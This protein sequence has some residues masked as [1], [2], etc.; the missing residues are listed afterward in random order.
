MYILTNLCLVN[1][2]NSWKY[3]FI[4]V[5]LQW[6]IYIAKIS[7]VFI[8]PITIRVGID[9][10][11]H[12]CSV[13]FYPD[14]NCRY[15]FARYVIKYVLYFTWTRELI[16]VYWLS[17]F[18]LIS[19]CSF[20]LEFCRLTERLWNPK[21]FISLYTQCYLCCS[22]MTQLLEITT[23]I[24]LLSLLVFGIFTNFGTFK[25]YDYVT[26]ALYLY[27]PFAQIVVFL[28]ARASIPCAIQAFEMTRRMLHWKYLKLRADKSRILILKTKVLRPLSVDVGL[29]DFRFFTLKRSTA[30]T[31]WKVCIDYTIATLLYVHV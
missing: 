18:F 26:P 17:Y 14:T 21:M 9:P 1:P 3:T 11:L 29:F 12:I 16:R 22:R 5:V 15:P 23:T 8:P 24:N 25:L 6:S 13:I 20:A 30:L 2:S 10:I 4:T 27:F 7:F 28:I 31:L 19:L